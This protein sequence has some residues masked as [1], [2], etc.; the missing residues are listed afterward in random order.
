MISL[1][2]LANSLWI[3]VQSHILWHWE[4]WCSM[5]TA[6]IIIFLTTLIVY[7]RI[8]DAVA[9]RRA[10]SLYGSSSIR[11]MTVLSEFWQI[12]YSKKKSPI[13]HGFE[14]CPAIDGGAAL[15]MEFWRSFSRKYVNWR[16]VP[17]EVD[18]RWF[19]REIEAKD[20][21]VENHVECVTLKS[22]GDPQ[23]ALTRFVVE[24]D[25]NRPF[26][27]KQ[28][29]WESKYIRFDDAANEVLSL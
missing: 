6:F 14:V 21:C 24:Q 20:F 10:R 4:S 17:V 1:L 8:G 13:V 26:D 23:A 18:G 12:L 22:N 29:Y 3:G 25:M 7:R 9:L 2:E 19:W 28:P 5:L 27:R 11:R 16:S 15:N